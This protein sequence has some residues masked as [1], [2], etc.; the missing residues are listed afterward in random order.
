VKFLALKMA[1]VVAAGVPTHT[2]K[3]KPPKPTPH[4][5][6]IDA[7]HR[8]AY[9]LRATL[10]RLR[11]CETRG[12]AYPANYR[13][14]GIHDGAYQYTPSTWARTVPYLPRRL[15]RVASDGPAH[16]A[17]PAEQDVRTAF[18]FPSHAGEWACKP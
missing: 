8:L 15:R 2:E 16:T 6:F 3:P 17:T 10:K 7:R 14:D 18:F 1:L 4:K 12:I 9:S 5:L 11:G 13:Y